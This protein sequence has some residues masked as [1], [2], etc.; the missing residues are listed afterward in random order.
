MSLFINL[1]NSVSFKYK[2]SRLIALH[3]YTNHPII[4]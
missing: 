4:Y 3:I 2:S 1:L